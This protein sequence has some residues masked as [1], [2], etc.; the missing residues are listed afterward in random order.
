MLLSSGF[1]WWP[2]LERDIPPA[3]GSDT[4]HLSL[5]YSW[6]FPW[7][8]FLLWG[9]FFFNPLHLCVHYKTYLEEIR[10]H[11]L[12]SALLQ[13]GHVQSLTPER[14]GQVCQPYLQPWTDFL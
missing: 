10:N 11:C 2:S 6:I 8:S 14:Q 12:C 4:F 3:A 13:L 9:V 7:I 1:Y 5:F